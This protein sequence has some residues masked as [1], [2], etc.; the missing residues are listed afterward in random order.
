VGHGH[1]A[2]RMGGPSMRYAYADDVASMLWFLMEDG[3]RGVVRMPALGSA[4]MDEMLGMAGQ[5]LGIWD[6][7]E[8]KGEMEESDVPGWLPDSTGLEEAVVGTTKWYMMNTWILK[9]T[10]ASS[11]PPSLGRQP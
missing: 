1:T 7:M 11:Q 9:T 4:T 5:A 2:P 8:Y 6:A 3:K 10:E